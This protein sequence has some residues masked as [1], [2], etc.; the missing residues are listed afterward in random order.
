MAARQTAEHSEARERRSRGAGVEVGVVPTQPTAKT[1]PFRLEYLF[2]PPL[3]FFFSPVASSFPCWPATCSPLLVK[4]AGR[5]VQTKALFAQDRSNTAAIGSLKMVLPISVS[6]RSAI[7]A[8]WSRLQAST[9][10]ALTFSEAYAPA[11]H[12]LSG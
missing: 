8:A 4:C 11:H 9:P 10:D 1:C 2:Q 12:D 6:T 7:L 3:L 5:P